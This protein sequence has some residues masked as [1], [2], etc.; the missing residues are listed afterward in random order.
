MGVCRL[1]NHTSPTISDTL[2]MCLDCIRSRPDEA[3]ILSAEIHARVRKAFG[4]PGEPPDDP[5]G[6]PCKRCVNRCRI[7][8]GETGCCGIRRNIAG[9]L[10]G[11]DARTGKLSWYRD[12]LPT[13]CVGDRVCP[14][15]TGA[16]FPKYAHCQ[17]PE[18]GYYN[19]AV[20]F[21][22]CTFNCLYCQNWHFRRETFTSPFRRA[23]ELA[24]AVNDRTSC[25]CYF[26]GDPSA[27][28]PFSL[29]TAR[30]A[31][32]K[33]SG[34]ILRICWETNGSVNEK[35]LDEMIDLALESGGCIKF[36]LKAWDET[37]HFALTGATNRQTLSNF[38]RAAQ[39]IRERP[40]P[41]PVIASTLLV[42]GYI[43]DREIGKLA[44]FI[45]SEDPAIPYSLLAFYPH[46]YMADLPLTTRTQAEQC[47]QA[48]T[49][50]GLS[51][52]RL[53]NVHLI[54]A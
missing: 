17:G 52:L 48:A 33:Q 44:A 16:G 47:V 7:P 3:R 14:G 35:L 26:G 41:P 8:P 37:L 5:A 25:I 36:D 13:N 54:Q 21:Q 30:L 22:A 42:P 50:A 24:A 40:V 18:K 4:L 43:D 39:R 45:A 28:M 51:R 6:V 9:R 19:L 53:G 12:P 38:Q 1:C 10:T 31:R 46:F 49:G 23:D 20:F 11:A 34:K 27:Q 32:K 29:Y 15:G 2:G